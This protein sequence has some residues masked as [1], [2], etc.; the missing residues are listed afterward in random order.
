MTNVYVCHN[1]KKSFLAKQEIN[2]ALS[3]A[4]SDLCVF[5]GWE[6]SRR[7]PSIISDPKA[8][9]RASA[10]SPPGVLEPDPGPVGL[11]PTETG[12]VAPDLLSIAARQAHTHTEQL[13]HWIPQKINILSEIVDR[14]MPTNML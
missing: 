13:Q 7:F 9:A 1:N 3:S 2:L 5:V 4:T 14:D 6:V 11:H 10:E 8:R 12:R